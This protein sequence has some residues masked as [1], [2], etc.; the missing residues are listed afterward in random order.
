MRRAAAVILFTLA[1]SDSAFAHSAARGFV[2]LL[3]T[4][5]VIVAGA[6][7]V[8]ASFAVV[9][10]LPDRLFYRAAEVR[11]GFGQLP[12][13]VIR[14][15]SVASAVA[16]GLLL[17][18]G[19]A[20]PHDPLENLLV[21]VVWTGWWVVI[22]LLHPLLGNLWGAL[23]PFAWIAPAV[24]RCVLP[25]RLLYVPALLIFAAFAWFQLV[26]PAPE[27]P[28]RLALVAG[29]YAVLTLVAIVVFGT[30]WLRWADP[31][32]IFLH[33]LGASAPLGHS[34]RG[35]ELRLP[36]A[37]LLRLAP[38]PVAGIVFV[39]LTLAAISF[40]GLS[41]TFFWL[42]SV[43]YNPLEY[44]GRTALVPAN[45]LGLVGMVLLLV[46]AF[47]AAV[48]AG[49]RWAGRPGRLIPLMGRLIFSL[50]PISI[51]YHFAHYLSDALLNMQYLVLAL[52]DPLGTGAQFLGIAPFHVTASFQNTASGALL[53]FSAQAAAIVV[54]HVV[55]V[56]VAHAMA[57]DLGLPRG[58]LLR[59][60][61]PLALLMVIYTGFG[62]W[63]LATPTAS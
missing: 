58:R 12:Q 25:G 20:G 4:T 48:T 2:L 63:L 33:Q 45:T 23:N 6:L 38:L 3:P 28:P 43:G 10:L 16:L 60:E 14:V 52:N 55:G 31:F 39:L 62:L 47:A 18:V 41:H 21:L 54:G 50:I 30:Q 9:S 27:D 8:L 22:V 1:G 44:P 7:A 61:A 37:G 11:M 29:A 56:A 51:A 46:L 19:V 5:H 17:W 53:L 32:A 57:L 35:V 34:E 49:W 40:D 15:L 24:G 59:F 26:Y 13:G 42:S 36:G